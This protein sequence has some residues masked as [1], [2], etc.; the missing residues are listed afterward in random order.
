M[1]IMGTILRKL[2]PD[3]EVRRRIKATQD[4]KNPEKK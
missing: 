4:K 2:N 3:Y 1:Y